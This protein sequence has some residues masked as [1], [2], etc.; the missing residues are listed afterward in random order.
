MART[1]RATSELAVFVLGLWTFHATYIKPLRESPTARSYHLIAHPLVLGLATIPNPIAVREGIRWDDSAG[2]ALA[3]K[4]DPT[5]TYQG[6]HY[7]AALFTYYVKLW[8]YDPAGMV[9][10]YKAKLFRTTDELFWFLSETTPV[11]PLFWPEKNGFWMKVM[12]WPVRGLSRMLTAG[13]L[14]FAMS[15]AGLVL[16][17]WTSTAMAWI[18][19]TIGALGTLAYLEAAII[20]SAVVLWYSAVLVFSIVFAGMLPF[21]LIL[22]AAANRFDAIYGSR[23]DRDGVH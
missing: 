1:L 20:M 15:L 2:E 11:E 12:G 17:R 9:A 18:V 5:A 22:L 19:C 4:I 8:L 13:G 6:E 7:E 16:R 23:S 3:R 21:E 10:I 14:L